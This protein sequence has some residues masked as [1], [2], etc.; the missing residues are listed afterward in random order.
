MDVHHPLTFAKEVWDSTRDVQGSTRPR[1]GVASVPMG[2]L[3]VW[4][5]SSQSYSEANCA[6]PKASFCTA[7]PKL[8][9]SI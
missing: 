5:L 6:S 8:R 9:L 4:V 7:V 3:S 2:V 1:A